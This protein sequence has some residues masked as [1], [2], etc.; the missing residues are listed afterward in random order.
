MADLD[1]HASGG[2]TVGGGRHKRWCP[3]KGRSIK[4]KEE[5]ERHRKQDIEIEGGRQKERSERALGSWALF[6][7]AEK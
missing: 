1:Q 3:K 5:R 4:L 2:D 6:W 7:A